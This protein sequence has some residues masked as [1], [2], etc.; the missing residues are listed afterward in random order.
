MPPEGT[1][2][3]LCGAFASTRSGRALPGA[4][5]IA[6]A[7]VLAAHQRLPFTRLITLVDV[8]LGATTPFTRAAAPN[9]GPAKAHVGAWVLLLPFAAGVANQW[10][11]RLAPRPIRLT[12]GGARSQRYCWQWLLNAQ[13]LRGAAGAQQ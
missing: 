12:A 4:L 11:I 8:L 10:P 3:D 9:A 6:A 2:F 1:L 5:A 7:G 13:Q